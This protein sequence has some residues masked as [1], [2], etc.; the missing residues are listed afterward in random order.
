MQIDHDPEEPPRERE[1]SPWPWVFLMAL[2]F[3][4]LRWWSVGLDWPSVLMGAIVAF[5]G[6]FLAVDFLRYDLFK[7]WRDT[8]R[9]RG[10]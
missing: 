3:A 6:S 7:S 8:R 10:S 1:R 9:D 4:G 2:C 5:A